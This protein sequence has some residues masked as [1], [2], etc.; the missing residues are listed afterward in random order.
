[1]FKTTLAASVAALAAAQLGPGPEMYH[2]E[3]TASNDEYDVIINQISGQDKFLVLPNE[4]YADPL[5]VI[6]Q[7][8][9]KLYIGGVWNVVP[10]SPLATVNFTCLLMGAVAYDV[11]YDCVAPAEGASND[12]G[13]CTLPAGTIGENWTSDFGFDVPG[14]A[15]P[16]D[17][18]VHVKFIAEDGTS[19]FEVESVFKIK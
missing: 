1:M 18:D 9:L 5:Q 10:E 4:T 14:I 16:F 11:T 6:K 7:S 13:N 15:P 17:Y 3:P 19:L 12:Y 2:V 8:T